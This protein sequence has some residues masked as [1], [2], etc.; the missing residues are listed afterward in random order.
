MKARLNAEGAAQ[1]S[2]GT[3]FLSGR[4]LWRCVLRVPQGLMARQGLW[5]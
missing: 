2:G 4:A 1:P 5:R 3:N